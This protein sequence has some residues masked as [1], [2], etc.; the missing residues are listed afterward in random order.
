MYASGIFIDSFSP[1][2][3]NEKSCIIN[4]IKSFKTNLVIVLDDQLQ[5]HHIRERL[6]EDKAFMEENNT[7]IVQLKKPQGVTSNQADNYILFQ[8]YFRGKN[9]ELMM[10][11]KD[12]RMQQIR[13]IKKDVDLQ[14]QLEFQQKLNQN[15]HADSGYAARGSEPQL[16]DMEAFEVDLKRNYNEFQTQDIRLPIEEYKIFEIKCNEIPV[17]A[18][19]AGAKGP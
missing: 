3:I 15:L 18:L 12:Q 1:K 6:R 16:L 14:S 7:Q 8:E 5:E 19:P 13:D 10:Q 9:Y 4:A 2:T 17:H 11:R